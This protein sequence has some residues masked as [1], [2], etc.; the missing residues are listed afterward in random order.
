MARVAGQ[1][2]AERVAD[3]VEAVLN[4]RDELHDAAIG[5]RNVRRR[6]PARIYREDALSS[7]PSGRLEGP[8]VVS[9]PAL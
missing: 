6:G 8:V 3:L 2:A 1:P 5:D 9:P 4:A 7:E